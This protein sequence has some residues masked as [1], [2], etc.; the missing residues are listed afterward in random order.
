MPKEAEPSLLSKMGHGTT[1]GGLPA[2]SIG[3]MSGIWNPK[4]FGAKIMN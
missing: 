3:N 1:A 2:G 4:D